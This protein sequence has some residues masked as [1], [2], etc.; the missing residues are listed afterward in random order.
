MFD[1][2]ASLSTPNNT[3]MPF[4]P[5][6]TANILLRLL[7]GLSLLLFLSVA[8]IHACFPSKTRSVSTTSRVTQ[9]RLLWGSWTVC[10]SFVR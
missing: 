3:S 7:P 1:N 9:R 8:L 2:T 6:Y 4:I 5:L 10:F